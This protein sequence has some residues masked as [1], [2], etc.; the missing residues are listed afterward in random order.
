MRRAYGLARDLAVLVTLASLSG[1]AMVFGFEDGVPFEA[2]AEAE[3]QT[4]RSPSIDAAVDSTS[5][6]EID[7]AAD[8]AGEIADAAASDAGG[9]TGHEDAGPDADAATRA[10]VPAPEDC[11]NG[12]DDDCDGLADCADPQCGAVGYRCVAAPAGWQGPVEIYEGPLPPACEAPYAGGE[13]DGHAAPLAFGPASCASCTC[14]APSGSSCSTRVTGYATSSCGGS[15]VGATLPA[16]ACTDVR[17]LSGDR[18]VS[19]ASGVAA[20]GSCAASGG[21]VTNRGAATWQAAGRACSLSATAAAGCAAGS[22]CAPTPRSPFLARFCVTQSGDVACPGAPF[23][24]RH[25]YYAGSADTRGCTSCACGAAAGVSCK[26]VVQTFQQSGCSGSSQAMSPPTAC[27]SL[28]NGTKSALYSALPLGG[29]CAASGG[30][31]TGTVTLVGAT[32]FCCSP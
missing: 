16:G 23:T 15:S 32:T 25:V 30:T 13:Y 5:P 20:G 11:T 21:G 28:P 19:V 7:A 6:Q 31:P 17:V 29:A 2:D 12:V 8:R 22:T 26:G 27:T 9:D 10:C 18:G 4:D 14:G 24:D 3:A 1:C